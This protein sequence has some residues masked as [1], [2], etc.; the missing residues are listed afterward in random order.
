VTDR[1]AAAFKAYAD[2]EIGEEELLAILAEPQPPRGRH[3]A[4]DC[5]RTTLR[6]EAVARP[7]KRLY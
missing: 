3:A 4:D 2:E 6:A 5:D 7:L 1:T